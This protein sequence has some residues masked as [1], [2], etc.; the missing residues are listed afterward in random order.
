MER[1]LLG[2]NLGGD[3]TKRTDERREGQRK[4]DQTLLDLIRDKVLRSSS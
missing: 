3:A 1:C 4:E 2:R